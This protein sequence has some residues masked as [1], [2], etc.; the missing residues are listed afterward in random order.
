SNTSNGHEYQSSLDVLV[1][2]GNGNFGS[3]PT[4]QLRAFTS[5]VAVGDFDGDGYDDL[6]TAGGQDAVDVRFSQGTGAFAAPVSLT[7]AGGDPAAG[8]VADLDGDGHLDLAVAVSRVV[9]GGFE[10]AVSVLPG[11]GQGGFA[12]KVDFPLGLTSRVSPG[13]LRVGDFNNDG[14]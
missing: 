9:G 4:I 5:W 13:S 3:A 8:A 12:P 11:D 14:K 10:T 1:G 6:A 2:D 7:V